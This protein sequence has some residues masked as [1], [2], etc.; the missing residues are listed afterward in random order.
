MMKRRYG[1]F[2]LLLI[3]AG[4]HPLG[5]QTPL[6]EELDDQAAAATVSYTHLEP[7]RH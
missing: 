2:A 1:I 5:A 4:G 6:L 7:T 3:L